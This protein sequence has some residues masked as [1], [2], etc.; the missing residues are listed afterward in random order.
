[1]TGIARID[2][3]RMQQLADRRALPD[4]PRRVHRMV[5]EPG[6][7]VARARLHP[8]CGTVR[9]ATCRRTRCRVRWR[10]RASARTR[11]RPPWAPRLRRSLRNAG[12]WL[13]SFQRPAAIVRAEHSRSEV[14]GLRGHEHDVRLARILHDVMNDVAEELRPDELPVAATRVAAQGK[15]TLAGPHP[16]RA[17]HGREACNYLRPASTGKRRPI[18]AARR[19]SSPW[20]D[21]LHRV[22]S[23]SAVSS[24][25]GDGNRTHVSSLGSY[26]STIELHPRGRRF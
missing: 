16:E 11:A 5:V 17:G 10:D 18:R 13:A 15:E 23:E 14:S 4:D 25:A 19:L 26:S 20:M 6:D 21:R 22:A 2:A 1:M 12:G 3:H 9:P 8:R 7:R 24:G